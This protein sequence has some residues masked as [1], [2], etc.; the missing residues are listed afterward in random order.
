MEYQTE[1][2]KLQLKTRPVQ[3]D[4]DCRPVDPG[5]YQRLDREFKARAIFDM[6]EAVLPNSQGW[7]GIVDEA[8]ETLIEGDYQT[9]LHT[10]SYDQLMEIGKAIGRAHPNMTEFY[11]VYLNSPA[12]TA[13]ENLRTKIVFKA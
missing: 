5:I 13:A 11:L 9:Y 12:D 3:F 8:G 7:L 10:G 4:E 2:I 1:T 6:W